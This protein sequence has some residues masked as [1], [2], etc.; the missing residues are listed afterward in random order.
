[1]IDRAEL[2]KRGVAMVVRALRK[3]QEEYKSFEDT[4]ECVAYIEELKKLASDIEKVFSGSHHDAWDWLQG[5]LD[6]ASRAQGISDERL[7]GVGSF[8]EKIQDDVALIS[9]TVFVRSAARA[10]KAMQKEKKP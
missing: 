6:E 9:E 10:I 8:L 7:E 3:D 2:R 1:M 5:Q 4:K